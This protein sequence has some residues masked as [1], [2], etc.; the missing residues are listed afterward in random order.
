MVDQDKRYGELDEFGA[1]ELV[2]QFIYQRSYPDYENLRRCL[3]D[4]GV[5]SDGI[6]E[7]CTKARNGEL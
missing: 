1:M 6:F 4:Y 5:D 7:I 2:S 3:R